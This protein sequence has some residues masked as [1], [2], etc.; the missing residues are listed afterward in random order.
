MSA[1][2]GRCADGS[3]ARIIWGK[4]RGASAREIMGVQG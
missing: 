2:G 1:A 4:F 3:V